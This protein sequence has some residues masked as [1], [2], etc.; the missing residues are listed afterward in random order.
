MP[1]K[2]IVGQR[3][4][5]VRLA[6]GDTLKAFGELINNASKGMVS[7]WERGEN[8]PNKTRL[9]KI[10]QIGDITVNELLYGTSEEHLKIAQEV[11]EAALKAS[12]ISA[13]QAKALRYFKKAQCKSIIAESLDHYLSSIAYDPDEG[14][15]ILTLRTFIINGFEDKYIDEAKTNTNLIELVSTALIDTNVKE[16]AVLDDSSFITPDKRYSVFVTKVSGNVNQELRIKVM[17]LIDQTLAQLKQLKNQ[18]PDETNADFDEITVY[19]NHLR[20]LTFLGT[21]RD[22]KFTSGE[23]VVQDDIKQEILKYYESW[24]SQSN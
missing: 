23:Q 7:N 18:Y 24:K 22:G 10:A 13:N 12:D 14:I 19:D 17:R 4:K 21:E 6:R 5:R 2:K 9:A 20:K 1:D 15:D 8:L 11:Y 3:I 16:Y